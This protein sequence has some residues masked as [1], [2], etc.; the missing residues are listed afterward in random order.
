MAVYEFMLLCGP[1]GDEHARFDG[2]RDVE[3][4]K[5]WNE[6]A[7]ACG[8]YPYLSARSQKRR[9]A[10][11][12]SGKRRLPLR[13]LHAVVVAVIS[14]SSLLAVVRSSTLQH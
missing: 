2:Y 9:M 4:T 10:H 13:R 5:G 6:V 12:A 1:L 11:S 14:S 3:S 8:P 7:K